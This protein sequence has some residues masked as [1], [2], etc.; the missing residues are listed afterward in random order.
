MG[1]V[2]DKLRGDQQNRDK[3]IPKDKSY[4]MF[5]HDV[6]S[7]FLVHIQFDFHFQIQHNMF[8]LYKLRVLCHYIQDLI[9][10]YL[11][12]DNNDHLDKVPE[13][14]YHCNFKSYHTHTFLKMSPLYSLSEQMNGFTRFDEGRLG[15]EF[16]LMAAK[17]VIVKVVPNT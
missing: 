5:A 6:N 15:L 1:T 11:Y 2:E 8:L 9:I 4:I 3:D 16:K 12:L 17:Y 14:K 10:H 7:T 13:N